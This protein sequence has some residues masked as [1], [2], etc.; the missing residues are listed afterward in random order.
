MIS[1]RMCVIGVLYAI[2]IATMLFVI[3]G[4]SLSGGHPVVLT[5]FIALMTIIM[6]YIIYIH[7]KKP[8]KDLRHWG[9]AFALLF[10]LYLVLPLSF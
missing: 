10:T 3:N 8:L 1:S 5:I 2:I 6:A 7:Y 4:L 9:I